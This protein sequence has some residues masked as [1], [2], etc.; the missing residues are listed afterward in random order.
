VRDVCDEPG[1]R[2]IVTAIIAMAR[3]LKLNI[4]AD[5][6][7]TEAQVEFLKGQQCDAAQGFHY[8]KA[9]HGDDLCLFLSGL[10]KKGPQSKISYG[11]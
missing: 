7:E 11:M 2:A 5:G 6:V 4:V 10:P 8:S 3:S 1:D 9:L